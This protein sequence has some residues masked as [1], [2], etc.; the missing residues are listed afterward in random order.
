MK[1]ILFAIIGI[2][3]I[4]IITQFSIYYT[5]NNLKYISDENKI[6]LMNVLEINEADSFNPIYKKYNSGFHGSDPDYY[7]IKYEISIEDYEKNDLVYYEDST[8][9]VLVDCHYK[10][11]KDD[12]TYICIVRAS[13]VHNKELFD[14]ISNYKRYENKVQNE[15][16]NQKYRYKHFMIS[17]DNGFDRSRNM[18]YK[19]KIYHLVLDNYQDYMNF[20]NNNNDVL[21]MTEEDFKNNFMIITDI[22]NV[23]MLGLTLQSFYN[24]DNELIIELNSYPE[25]TEYNEKESAISIMIP[26][27]MKRDIILKNDMR[28]DSNNSYAWKNTSNKGL[29][30]ITEKQAVETAI[31][32]A[33]ILETSNSLTGKY[34]RNFN[35]VFEINL[36]K[37]KPNN[38]WLITEGILERNLRMADF[39][40]DAYEVILVAED[41]ELE[42][43]RAFFYVDLYTNEVIAGREM[44]D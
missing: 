20:K 27:E 25:G 30:P 44:A 10:E 31:S 11:K 42:I 34:L 33:K 39:E 24:N 15:S 37:C 16:N 40:R 36:T 3:L 5:N 7:E 43:M 6:K 41:D 29:T 18:E 9:E 38:Y 32:F 12:T 22:E 17:F 21:E 4:V 19:D 26:R 1:K 8:Y 28:D 35:K 14:K 13:N 23:S 2:I